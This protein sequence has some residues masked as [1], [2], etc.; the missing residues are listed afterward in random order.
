MC[1]VGVP[2]APELGSTGL[3]DDNC[4]FMFFVW[5]MFQM[6]QRLKMASEKY[7]SL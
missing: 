6:A 5:K 2:P 1:S 7:A 3:E 4:I